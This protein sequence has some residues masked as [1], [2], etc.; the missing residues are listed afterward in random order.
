MQSSKRRGLST[1]ALVGAVILTASFT[2]LPVGDDTA[3]AAGQCGFVLGAM[4]GSDDI[5]G[6]S[7]CIAVDETG[8]ES[9]S[10]GDSGY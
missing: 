4:E 2:V 8:F 7:N 9:E 5:G 1:K 10:R 3:E 6:T